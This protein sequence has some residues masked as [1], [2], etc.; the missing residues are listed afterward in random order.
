MSASDLS[1]KDAIADIASQLDFYTMLISASLAILMAVIAVL[2]P[3]DASDEVVGYLVQR[4]LNL[5]CD[6]VL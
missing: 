5:F 6:L 1:E 3:P 2:L 4:F